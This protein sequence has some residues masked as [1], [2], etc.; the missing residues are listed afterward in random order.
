MAC[1]VAPQPP[2]QYSHAQS[3]VNR[4]QEAHVGSIAAKFQ[5]TAFLQVRF[6]LT[7]EYT[8]LEGLCFLALL[9]RFSS[10]TLSILQISLASSCSVTLC[11]F[12]LMMS[13]YAPHVKKEEGGA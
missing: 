3:K 13:C 12:L 8:E 5:L 2:T 10:L 1:F 6:A 9:L 11:P 7:H 4:L